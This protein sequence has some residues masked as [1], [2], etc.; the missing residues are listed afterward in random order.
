[1]NDFAGMEDLMQD[2]LVESSKLLADID[3][4]LVGMESS[5]EDTKLFEAL[6][7]YFHTIKGG[8]G[9]LNASE[10]VQLCHLGETLFDRLRNNELVVDAGMMDVVRE[11]NDQL[12]AMFASLAENVQPLPPPVKLIDALSDLLERKQAPARHPARQTAMVQQNPPLKTSPDWSLFHRS[13]AP[14]SVVA[15]E[16]PPL[17]YRR[18]EDQSER[19]PQPV[20]GYGRRGGRRA[21]DRPD[22]KGGARR[23]IEGEKDNT[24]RVDADRLNQALNLSGELEKIKNNLMHLLADLSKNN[25]ESAVLV[26]LDEAVNQIDAFTKKFRNAIVRTRMQPMGR[27]FSKFKLLIDDLSRQL[28]KSVELTLEGAETELDTNVI[29]Q[30][31]EPLVHL[32]RNAVIHGIENPEQRMVSGKPEKGLVRLCV[33][34]EENRVVIK[35]TD[36]GSGMQ[37]DAIRSR[38]VAQRLID[39]ELAKDMSRKECLNLVFLPG[40]SNRNQPYAGNGNVGGLYRAQFGIK[41]LGGTISMNAEFGRGTEFTISLPLKLALLQVRQFKLNEKLLALPSPLV[42]G[43][44]PIAQSDLQQVSGQTLM[45]VRGEILPVLPLAKLIGWNETKAPRTGVHIQLDNYQFIIAVDEDA[46][47]NEVA[48]KSIDT[49]RPKGMAGASVSGD[50]SVMLILDVRELLADKLG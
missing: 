35:L 42:R 43:V 1:M 34:Q 26:S 47:L 36:D 2:F 45:L 41:S 21:T 12:K 19:D 50:G 14:R 15:E 33:F 28:N 18:P 4:L 20:D 22:G 40:F 29:N 13:L 25:Y 44:F 10:M 6:F 11:L 9:F 16:R 24:I 5:P 37:A 27:M 46:G 8:A 39:P 7:R 38:A 23:K 48:F 3:E 17:N 32:L 30:L 31:N 49:M